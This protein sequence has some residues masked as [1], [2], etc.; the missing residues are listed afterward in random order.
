M[1]IAEQEARFTLLVMAVVEA[2]ATT[3]ELSEFRE[4]MRAHPEFKLQYL[5]QM[6][7][8]GLMR[9]RQEIRTAGAGRYF[10][11]PSVVG[12][13]RIWWKVAAGLVA[14]ALIAVLSGVAVNVSRH[15]NMVALAT[16]E[17]AY[18]EVSVISGGETSKAREGRQ[19]YTGD[20]LSVSGSS[21]AACVVWEDGSRLALPAVSRVVLSRSK[22]EKRITLLT[23]SFD[24]TFSKQLPGETY[25]IVTP[26]G[27]AK[28]LGTTVTVI[29]GLRG[30][31]FSVVQGRVR[32][33]R[34]IDGAKT[35]VTSRHEVLLSAQ[36]NSGKLNTTRFYWPDRFAGGP[37]A[38]A[39]TKQFSGKVIGKSAQGEP[40]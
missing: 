40:K 8:H 20:E 33:E 3:E 29:R 7:I 22:A 36:E 34:F 37:K 9:Y 6:K 30:T 16:I 31:E 14:A 15:D 24:A 39:A 13:A 35:D 4:L 23:G 28:V 38:G 19:L 1:S 32:V 27:R 11:R 26:D 21:G 5:E 17:T 2:T 18:G 12:H 10:R 25:M